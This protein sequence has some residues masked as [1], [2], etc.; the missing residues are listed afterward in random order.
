MKSA[1]ERLHAALEWNTRLLQRA[2]SDD[3]PGERQHLMQLQ[4][5]QRQRLH[6]TYADL[7]EQ[8]RFH[9]A[10]HFFLDELYG[11]EDFSRR[12]SELAR[13]EPIMSRLMPQHLLHTV[14][15]ALEVQALS[16]DLDWAVAQQLAAIQ[17]ADQAQLA[18]D[19]IRYAQAYRAAGRRDD[20]ERQLEMIAEVGQA[21]DSV[22]HKGWVQRLLRLLRGPATAAGFGELQE[23]LESGFAAFKQMRGAEHFLQAIQ[24]RESA[25]MEAIFAGAERP[26][27]NL[28]LA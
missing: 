2:N 15:A 11:G 8:E 5:W 16:L 9:D 19:Q 22:V 7:I 23:F 24:E 21:L 13:V 28:D 18:I 25:A 20:R 14:A 3:N 17:H 4:A 10:C 1:A 26:F 12:H 6:L 27:P